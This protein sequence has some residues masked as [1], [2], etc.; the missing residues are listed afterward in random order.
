MPTDWWW[1]AVTGLMIYAA[2][3]VP[4]V[5]VAL[6]VAVALLWRRQRRVEEFMRVT[7]DC[8][9]ETLTL[10]AFITADKA[11]KEVRDGEDC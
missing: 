4:A 8:V 6:A 10:V 9:A 3:L 5:L 11:F 7:A 1:C 2:V